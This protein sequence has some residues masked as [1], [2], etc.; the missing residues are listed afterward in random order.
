MLVDAADQESKTVELVLSSIPSVLAETKCICVY[1]LQNVKCVILVIPHT[2]KM[3]SHL[4]LKRAFLLSSYHRK[5]NS[6]MNA[7]NFQC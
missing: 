7:N 6:K 5:M 3:L 2:R 4:H 1:K